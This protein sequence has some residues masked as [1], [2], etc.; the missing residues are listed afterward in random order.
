MAPFF[1][2]RRGAHDKR[3]SGQFKPFVSAINKVPRAQPQSPSETPPRLPP[4]SPLKGFKSHRR[5]CIGRP[6]RAQR[7][8]LPP[9]ES[10]SLA[11]APRINNGEIS[12]TR[13][14]AIF[15]AVSS[16]W[17]TT[18]PLRRPLSPNRAASTLSET[19]LPRGA[20][21]SSHLRW[22]GMSTHNFHCAHLYY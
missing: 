20:H 11:G 9:C 10:T 2:V 5:R 12:P 1:K 3:R 7:N 8:L 15:L 18:S 19:V 6:L 16:R 17:T 14:T 22:T 21:R 13:R 4:V